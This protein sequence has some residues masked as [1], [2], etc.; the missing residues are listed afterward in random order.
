MLTNITNY[1][2]NSDWF[3]L[4]TAASVVDYLVILMTRY[5]GPDPYFK[6]KALNEW[7]DR[8]GLVAAICDVGSALIGLAAA[9]FTLVSFLAF[10]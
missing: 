4:I 7:Y 5:P 2:Q 1:N 10:A 8:F 3:F 6:V 9:R